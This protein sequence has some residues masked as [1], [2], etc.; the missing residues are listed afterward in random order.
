MPYVMAVVMVKKFQKRSRFS[1]SRSSSTSCRV[2]CVCSL[3][4][5]WLWLFPLMPLT[6]DL[7]LLVSSASAPPADG[8]E[9]KLVGLSVLAV[10]GEDAA[11]QVTECDSED[12]Q[13]MA[14]ITDPCSPWSNLRVYG[15]DSDALAMSELT[16]N[17][18]S[19]SAAS[20]PLSETKYLVQRESAE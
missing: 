16:E 8:A 2:I 10:P 20:T 14:H 18:C 11:V 6:N 17:F 19:G 9:S 1:I 12:T 15:P 3:W 7:T 5:L 13:P 4:R